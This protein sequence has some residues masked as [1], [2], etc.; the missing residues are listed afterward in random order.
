MFQGIILSSFYWGYVVTHLP[1][2]IMAEKF[3]GKYS[4]GLGIL[5]TAVFTLL[6]P[7]A[8]LWGGSTALII[9]RVCMGLGEGVTFPALNAMLAQWT[10]PEE[11]SKIGSLVFA[12]AQL[13]T[14]VT[15]S[16][17]GLILHYSPLG[18]PAVFY[19]F[20]AIGV[21]WFIVWTL[22]CYNN[23][24]EHPFISDR[25][26]KYLHERLSDHTSKEPA[27]IPWRHILKSPPFLAL[28]AAQIGHDWGFF[29]MVTDLPKY[30]SGV[31]KFSIK[32]NGFLSSLP[33]LC[34]WFCSII[35]SCLADWLIVAGY[36]STTNV[37][38]L[39]TTIASIGPGIFI[40]AASYSGCDKTLVVTMF[41]IAMT[42]MGTFYPGM[43]VNALDLSPNYSGTLMALTNGIGAFTGILTP[44][45]V[46]ELAPDGTRT[47]WQLVFWIVLVVLAVT[48]LIFVIY[49]S[50]DTQLWNNPDY[51]RK[52]RDERRREA[53][54][55]KIDKTMEK[56][57][58]ER[59]DK[60]T[61]YQH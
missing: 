51:L 4:L 55:E 57:A 59:K 23:P 16:L 58:K 38:K 47:Q 35:S 1:G 3:G 12:G 31:L 48:N 53:S 30:M 54:N 40:I 43:K 14:V 17:S 28:I 41:T 61:D 46:G 24:D 39:G 19:L 18:W 32:S 34:M 26:K 5:S 21:L 52:E 45:V 49:A 44:L 33:Y 2:G 50:G 22:I 15:S 10:P 56:N 36:M 7:V 6:T 37:R 20:G 60:S 9:L 8:V 13:G 42:L 25:E 11:R 29:T 27:S